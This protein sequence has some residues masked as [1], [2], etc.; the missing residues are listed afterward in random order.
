MIQGFA[1]GLGLGL[2]LGLDLED[3]DILECT[4]RERGVESGPFR[5]F[6]SFDE[7]SFSELRQAWISKVD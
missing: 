7:K 2:G 3:L 6:E 1:V 4:E 5:E